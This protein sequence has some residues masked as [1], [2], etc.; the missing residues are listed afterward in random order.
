MIQFFK[1]LF[2]DHDFLKRTWQIVLPVT[3]QQLLSMLTNMVDNVMIGSLGEAEIGGVG[4]AAKVFFIVCLA[5]FGVSS[6]M[7]V[8]S[9]QYWGNNDI[10]NIRRVVGLGSC[11]SVGFAV[12][13]AVVCFFAPESAMSIFTDSESLIKTGAVYLKITSFSWPLMAISDTLATGLRTMDIVK[14]KVYISS[15]AIAV[16]V[17]FNYLLIF[18]KFGFPCLGV[19]GAAYATVI[20]RAVEMILTIGC[21]KIIKSPLWCNIK[22]YFGFTKEMF[23]Q[24][25]DRAMMV[26]VNDTLWGI[27]YSMHAL[28]Y[29]RMGEAA[30]AA[31]SV[32]SIFSDIEVVGLLG[33]ATACAVILGNELGAGN[34]K[35]AERYSRYYIALGLMTG[36]LICVIMLI[37]AGPAAR[38][39]NFSPEAE[40]MTRSTLL[41]L[42]VSLLW[43]ADN[44]ITI[45]GILRAGGDTKACAM[46]DLLP[47]WLVSVPLVIITGN[48][49]HWPLWA[50]YL[51]QQSDEF[52]KL[53][54][55]M[56]RVKSKK[57]LNN[58]N[59]ELNSKI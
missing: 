3:V 49:F 37:A 45:V 9:A 41:V 5:V 22:E 1:D 53:F 15:I 7:S 13:F 38:M 32:V 34:L 24:F 10:P 4:L 54:I 17:I 47:M 18:G 33:L 16:N 57:W 11:L 2:G 25:M 26:F 43:R 20:A 55:S 44:N 8:L 35:K 14:P 28:T 31:F 6:G 42:A 46:I 39:Y 30:A 27:G 51:I 52:I 58:L 21:L 19:A 50:V 56:A 59:V 23:S 40:E 36:C 29:G 12:L 48:K